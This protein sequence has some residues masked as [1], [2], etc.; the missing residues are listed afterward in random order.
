MSSFDAI[1]FTGDGKKL[2][3]HCAPVEWAEN[4]NA[5]DTS[6]QPVCLVLECELDSGDTCAE[7]QEVL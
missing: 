5:V 2:C 3:F 4:E 6:G 7:C 1:G